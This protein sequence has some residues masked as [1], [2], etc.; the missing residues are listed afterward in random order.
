MSTSVKQKVIKGGEFLT[1]ET[2]ASEIFIPEEF[3]EEQLMIKQSCQDFLDQEDP[4]VRR[5]RGVY[6]RNTVNPSQ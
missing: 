5:F 1:K 4:P 6:K 3:S 2:D